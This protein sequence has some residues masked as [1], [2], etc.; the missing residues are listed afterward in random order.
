MSG[1]SI[2]VAPGRQSSKPHQFDQ[3]MFTNLLA[4]LDD[5]TFMKEILD[6]HAPD[7]RDVDVQSLFHLVEEILGEATAIVDSIV[8]RKGTRGSG[9]PAFKPLKEGTQGYGSPAFE[10][11]KESFNPTLAAINEVACQIT[12]KAL[13]T[14]NVRK[15]LES[16][17]NELLS[18]S[19][20]T[21]AVIALSSL[22]LSYGDFW[23]LARTPPS[24]K[25]AE[26]TAIL[27]GL[28]A[29]TNPSNRQK[30][31]VYGDLNERIKTTLTMTKCIVDFEHDSKGFPELSTMID[32]PSSIY[33]IIIGVLACSIQF[34]SLI[35]LVDDY[36]GKDLPALDRKVNGI[37]L[38]IKGQSDI[39]KH[40]KEE[41]EEER[42][43]KRIFK[44]P[45]DNVALIRA[46]FYIKNDPQP[47]V[48]GS[49][50]NI[51]YQV[52]SLRRKN[53]MVLI[54]DLNMSH[55]DLSI[56][57]KIYSDP[58]FKEHRYEIVWVPI[59]DREGKE[60][61]DQFQKLRVQM[62]WYSVFSL[63]LIY[64]LAIK[65]MKEEWQLR[66]ETTVTVLDPQGRVS[67][68]NAMSITRF[69][70][71][72]P[73]LFPGHPWMA[74]GNFFAL[75]VTDEIFPD[76]HEIMKPENYILLYGA[77]DGQAIQDIEK[78]LQKIKGDGI[79]LVSR[80]VINM[81]LFWRH[82][83]SLMH[84]ILTWKIDE[85]MREALMRDV[86]NL[87][88]NLKKDRGF[89]VLTKGS[90]IVT[91]DSIVTVTD[92]LSQYETNWKKQVKEERKD[93]DKA[94][95]DVRN[96]LNDHPPCLN[97]YIPTTVADIPGYVKCPDCQGKMKTYVNCEC[98]CRG[99]HI[100]NH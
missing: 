79:P 57:K 44:K 62:P 43:L 15:T 63:G 66:Q 6:T 2:S 95:V 16:L 37:Y 76:R 86:L 93:F 26:L 14:N 50:L 56:L 39:I 27:K 100:V 11:L 24:D 12:C 3:N 20:V 85:N 40:K 31:Q 89:A 55:D 45:T 38:A 70:G 82:L 25:L 84:L 46:L 48:I 34:T 10:P 35:S 92:V 32:L 69:W 22:A 78:P 21:K 94:F 41:I 53:V 18:Y 71:L 17:F 51:K 60:V 80:K 29:I 90:Q 91:N 4:I 59:I 58:K 67:V 74:D 47:L 87:Y 30:I 68:Q 99:A 65:I 5:Q 64:K 75:L 98:C 83:G 19:W 1:Q 81:P 9:S 8:D 96:R 28:P 49:E 7:E 61:N 23:R 36:K 52:E 33:R 13:D 42:R 54:S 77:E 73:I 72:G 88:T 97:F